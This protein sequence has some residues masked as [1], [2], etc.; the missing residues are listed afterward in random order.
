MLMYFI[1]ISSYYDVYK[2]RIGNC[3]GKALLLASMV[4]DLLHNIWVSLQ[5]T[6]LQE[7]DL[8]SQPYEWA[9]LIVS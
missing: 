9:I 8:M 5:I 3:K 2:Y 7:I 6:V 4:C 1:L